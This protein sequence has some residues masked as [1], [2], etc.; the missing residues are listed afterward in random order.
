M[1]YIISAIR[2]AYDDKVILNTA[3]ILGWLS[4]FDELPDIELYMLCSD[5]IAAVARKLELTDFAD[6][7]NDRRRWSKHLSESLSLDKKIVRYPK[8][9]EAA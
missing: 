7:H 6:I 4:G 3:P 2:F 8:F 5:K 1:H 9:R